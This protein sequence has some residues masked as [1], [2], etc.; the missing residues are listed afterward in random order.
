[1]PGSM[2][3]DQD[4]HCPHFLSRGLAPHGWLCSLQQLGHNLQGV[5]RCIQQEKVFILVFK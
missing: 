1:M 2:S 4:Y 3:G 5:A